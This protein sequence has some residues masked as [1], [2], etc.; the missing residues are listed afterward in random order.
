MNKE[1]FE[2]RLKEIENLIY[3]AI[4][5]LNLLE[6]R[7]QEIIFTLEKMSEMEKNVTMD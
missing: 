2:K 7:K 6:G 4:S 3:Q 1:H 5:N